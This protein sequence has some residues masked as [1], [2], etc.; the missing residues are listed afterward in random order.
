[1]A[2]AAGPNIVEDGLVFYYD[3]ENTQ[4]SW[5]GK[6]TTN[7]VPT[8][9]ST[10]TVDN[11][12]SVVATGEYYRGNPVYR[13]TFPAGT[14]PRF[15]WNFSYSAGQ[16]FTGSVYY[17]SVSGN[18][19]NPA[20]YFREIN[21]GNSYAQVNFDYTTEWTKKEITHTFAGTGT[22]MFLF[23][24][25]SSNTTIPIVIDLAL[26]QVEQNSFATPFVNGTRSDTQAIVDLVG[27]NTV[28]AQSLTYN[29]DNTF[30]FDGINDYID[31]GSIP[32]TGKL[33]ASAWVKLNATGIFQHILDSS[34]N[35]WHLA[36]LS[37]NRPYLYNAVTNHGAAPPLSVNTWYMITGVQGTTLDLYIN[38][39]LAQ[40]IASNVN[41]TTN[42]VFVGAWQEPPVQRYFN[43]N[44]D[45]AQIYNRALSAAEVQQNFNA[46]RGRYG[47]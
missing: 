16:T 3:M 22:S 6:P 43:G 34:N 40:S 19:S 47:I 28:T 2:C 11:G 35:S 4:K 36:I 7:V 26:P 18:Q 44:I 45:N 33:T 32:M 27:G 37:T 39:A 41:V 1:M 17:R 46:L 42:N 9:L 5:K 29:S 15:R 13:A 20:L 30:E 8:N 10:Y 24:R 25:S 38:G 14:L 23:Y 12:C 21:F 31:C